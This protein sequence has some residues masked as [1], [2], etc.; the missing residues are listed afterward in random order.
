MS[1][2]DTFTDRLEG[3][4]SNGSGV[5]AVCPC[6]DD[7]NPSLDISEKPNGDLLIIC[8]SCGANG[9]DVAKALGLSGQDL[10]TEV[11]RGSAARVEVSRYHYTDEAGTR[12]FDAVRHTGKQFAL[13]LPGEMPRK[14]AMSGVR[15]VLY[16]LP[17]VVAAVAAGRWVM[18]VEGEKDADRLADLDV[19]ATTNPMGALKWHLGDYSTALAGAKVAVI[20]DNDTPGRKHARQVVASVSKVAERVAVVDLAEIWPE[21]PEKADV[22]DWL[23]GPGDLDTLIQII[24]AA[25]PTVV[26]T[27]PWTP[28]DLTAV[29]AQG[30]DPIEPDL[31]FRRDGRALLYSGKLNVIFATP[32][33]GKTWVAI[34]AVA[35]L[36]ATTT[37]GEVVAVFIDYEDDAR[38][39]LTRLQALG[40]TPEQAARHTRYYSMA[41]AIGTA[42]ETLE[43]LA[44]AKLVVVDTTNSAMTLADLDP[45]SN[46]DALAF[47]NDVRRLRRGNPAGW[48]LLDHEPISTGA[49]RRQAIGAQSKLGAV[50]GAQ[51]RAAAVAQPRPGAGGAISLHVT[52]DRAGGVRQY[53]AA[54][55]EYGIQH[56]ATLFLDPREASLVGALEWSIVEPQ[57]TAGDRELREAILEA[58]ADWSSKNQLKQL[59][60]G[61][62]VERSNARINET[63]DELAGEGLLTV[64]PKGQHVVY[65]GDPRHGDHPHPEDRGPAGTTQPDSQSQHGSNPVPIPGDHLE[66]RP[67]PGPTPKGGPAGTTTSFA[68]SED[69]SNTDPDDRPDPY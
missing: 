10:Y 29:A 64:K 37:D 49:N 57:G 20:P 25:E 55:N 52:K 61:Q 42:P 27:E 28:A 34:V 3:V 35:Q 7:H 63:V 38:S 15:R 14:E 48:L 21:A 13:A 9:T 43:G 65:K 59:V 18:V 51:Y 53:A 5:R 44:A 39:Y 16:R 69:H 46:A 60:R 23:D 36:I 1:P 8:R 24:E 26:E 30:L 62:G 11:H 19:V 17:E 47:I 58:A 56:A 33:A 66:P 68:A 45:L 2:L 12:L 67:V 41:Q 6:H 32:E 50:D 22:S 54:A 40:I 4:T 31:L